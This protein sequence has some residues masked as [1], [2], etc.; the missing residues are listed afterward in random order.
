[1][2]QPD[3]RDLDRNDLEGALAVWRTTPQRLRRDICPI[4]LQL[5]DDPDRL[6]ALMKIES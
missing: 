5:Q 2:K 3:H 1:M 4:L 6:L